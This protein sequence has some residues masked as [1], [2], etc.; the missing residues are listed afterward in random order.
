LFAATHSPQFVMGAIQSGASVD[1][2]R[3]TY[4]GGRATARLLPNNEIIKLLRN[5]LLR[6]ANVISALFYDYVIVSE[7]DSDR[8]FYQEINERLLSFDAVRGIPSALFINA[9]NKQTIPSIVGPL[10]KLGIPAAGI[11]DIDVLKDGGQEWTK[12]LKALSIP[13]IEYQPLADLRDKLWKAFEATG[14]NAKREGGIDLLS[15]TDKEAA[16]NLFDKLQQ[17]GLFVVRNGE[18]ESWLAD[19]NVPKNKSAWLNGIFESMGDDPDKPG[20]L[21]PGEGD[22]WDF[23]SALRKWLVDSERKGIPSR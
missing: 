15:G 1:I 13:D 4:G 18:V 21:K 8:A 5:P 2:I 3:L 23:I 22:V 11:V 12:H 17:Y 10:R 19:I 16:S 20:Y 14:K 6:S 9:Q 7:G